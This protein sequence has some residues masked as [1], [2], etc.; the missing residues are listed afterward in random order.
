MGENSTSNVCYEYKN[1]TLCIS[2]TLLIGV[3]Y[4]DNTMGGLDLTTLSSTKPIFTYLRQYTGVNDKRT[5]G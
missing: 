2:V 4:R 5:S 3:A 1:C